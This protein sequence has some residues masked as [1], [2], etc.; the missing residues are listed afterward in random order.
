MTINAAG[1]VAFNGNFG[2][3]GRVLQTN[4]TGSAPTWIDTASIGTTNGKLYFF[5]QF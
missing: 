3:A 4:G 5:G 2:V 1:A